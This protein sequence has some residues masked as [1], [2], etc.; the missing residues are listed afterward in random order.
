MGPTSDVFKTEMDSLYSGKRQ[1]EICNVVDYL[2]KFNPTKVAVEV[3]KKHE[4]QLNE[5]YQAYLSGDYKLEMN[6]VY[7][8]GFRI[9]GELQHESIYCIDWMEKGVAQKDAG[10]VYE[11]TKLNKPELFKSIYGWLESYHEA[12]NNKD[13]YKSILEM[14][15]G[16]ND[17]E[18]IKQH[19]IMNINLAR[20]KTSDEYIG[21]DW[22]LWWYQRNLIMFSHLADLTV[23]NEDRILLIVGAGHVEILSNFLEESG[24]FE[25]EQAKEYLY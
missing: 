8:L 1:E 12:I 24:L 16:I 25:I 15:R 2:I 5:Q 17:E 18:D 14:Y 22:L 20:I 7:Q 3:E 13:D 21:M 9:A 6:E 10:D 4:S 11:W 23:S 19:H